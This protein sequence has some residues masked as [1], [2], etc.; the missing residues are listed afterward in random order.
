LKVIRV[1]S[2]R[3]VGKY[4]YANRTGREWNSFPQELVE[5]EKRGHFRTAIIDSY[6]VSQGG[7]SAGS[8]V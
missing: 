7:W 6:T 3:D 8:A 2:K 5:L 1:G 4:S